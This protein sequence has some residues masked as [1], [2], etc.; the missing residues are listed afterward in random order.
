MMLILFSPRVSH[1]PV[2]GV[3]YCL[4]LAGHLSA[5]KSSTRAKISCIFPVELGHL[6]P[7]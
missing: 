5:C 2:C 3:L 7:S 1:I 6:L 4:V